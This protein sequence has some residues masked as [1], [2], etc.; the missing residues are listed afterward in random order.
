MALC[1]ATADPPAI[2]SI[3]ASDK[4]LWPLTNGFLAVT[5]PPAL[6][7]VLL[8]VPWAARHDMFDLVCLMRR[9]RPV[10][11]DAGDQK[12]DECFAGQQRVGARRLRGSGFA[13]HRNTPKG[14]LS[15][16]DVATPR[17][18][19]GTPC[20][21][22]TCRALRKRGAVTNVR[23]ATAGIL[24]AAR[25]TLVT[26]LFGGCQR[27]IFLAASEYSSAPRHHGWPRIRFVWFARCF[28]M[29]FRADVSPK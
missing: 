20:P 28:T 21:P 17:N 23:E 2:D 16:R 22:T 6:A 8:D 29:V 19:W 10:G 11:S 5:P 24:S 7:R 14:N 27:G 1:C 12:R 3:R 25:R 26:G 18:A 9:H 4:T 13:D 15:D